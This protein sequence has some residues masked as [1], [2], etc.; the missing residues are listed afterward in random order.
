MATTV[1]QKF[2]NIAFIW[3]LPIS[4]LL[5]FDKF[6]LHKC[7]FA[8]VLSCKQIH[9]HFCAT[10]L[11]LGKP[12]LSMM[13]GNL[14]ISCPLGSEEI[15]SKFSFRLWIV[16]VIPQFCTICYHMTFDLT[17]IFSIVTPLPIIVLRI[18][19]IYHPTS[20]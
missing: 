15:W 10:F 17:P 9:T 1:S 6:C 11:K 19:E 8:D 12:P 7:F 3:A 13:G 18:V 20:K 2:L 5:V 14:V 4:F 16:F